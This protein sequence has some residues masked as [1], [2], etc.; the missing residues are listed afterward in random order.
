MKRFEIMEKFYLSKALLAGGGNASPPPVDP[1]LTGTLLFQT[2]DNR[3][4][5]GR[6]RYVLFYSYGRTSLATW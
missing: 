1:F 2:D 5:Q 4:S 3:A 6:M